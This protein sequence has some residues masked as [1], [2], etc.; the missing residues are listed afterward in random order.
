MRDYDGPP[1]TFQE[2]KRLNRVLLDAFYALGKSRYTDGRVEWAQTQSKMRANR[3]AFERYEVK[4]YPQWT[5]PEMMRQLW[6]ARSAYIDS[7]CE[8]TLDVLCHVHYNLWHTDFIETYA[9]ADAGKLDLSDP[10]SGLRKVVESARETLDA[11]REDQEEQPASQGRPLGERLQRERIGRR[12]DRG[13]RGRCGDRRGAVGYGARRAGSA[14]RARSGPAGTVTTRR[15]GRRVLPWGHLTDAVEC[16]HGARGSKIVDAMSDVTRAGGRVADAHGSRS[17]G[18]TRASLTS[19][20]PSAT[21]IWGT[22]GTR[23]G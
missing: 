16:C 14:S 23:R 8:P 10:F 21:A 19:R 3:S 18:L 6:K 11:W 9:Q 1:R 12:D 15:D 13:W 5:H 7:P 4:H 20:A 22:A 17:C 2:V